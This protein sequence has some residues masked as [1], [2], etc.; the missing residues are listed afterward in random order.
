MRRNILSLPLTFLT[1]VSAQTDFNSS[2]KRGLVDITANPSSDA[3]AILQDSDITWYYN[4]GPLPSLDTTNPNL[5]FIPMLF[6][7][8]ETSTTFLS[9]VESLLNEG[10][11]PFVFSYNEPDGDTSSGGSDITPVAAAAN[12]KAQLEPLRA[13]GVKLGAPAV[14]G[15]P[16][17]FTWL[18]SF[19][20]ACDGGCTAD[21]MT[22]HWYGNFE[23]LQSNIEQKRT[24]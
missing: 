6:S 2:S 3:E 11:V 18:Q 1:L 21:F 5:T 20:E 23:G 22:V 8:A 17:G 15:S 16:S 24:A 10:P 12:W 19:F 9:T 7:T 4:Y 13:M 14:T